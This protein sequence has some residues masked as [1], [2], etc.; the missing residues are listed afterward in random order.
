MKSTFRTILFWMHLVSGLVAG[1]IIGL[2]S[3]TGAALAFEP[4]L[5]QWADREARQ[6]QPPPSGA[7]RLPVEELLARVRAAK[8]GVQPQGVTV[9]ADPESA[10]LVSTGR[11]SGVYVDPYTGDVR[12]QGGKG[13]RAFLHQMEELHRWLATSEDHRALGRG[14]TGVCN[15]AFLF[16]AVSGL[17]LWWPRRWTW[18]T[19]RPVLWFKGGLKGKARDFNWHNAAGFWAMPILVVLTASGVVMSY[20]AVSDLIFTLTGNEPPANSGPFGQTAVKVP[21]PPPGATPLGVDA[22][23]AEAQKQVPAWE[24]ISL[25]MG[26]GPRPGGQREGGPREGAPREGGPRGPQAMTFSIKEQGG[27]PLF[28]S[29]QLSLNPFT[30]EVLRRETFADYNSGRQIRTWLRFL[31]TGQALG[32]AG[33][34]VAGVASL[35][36]AFLMW[37]GFT[38]SWRRFFRRRSTVATTEQELEQ[39]PVVS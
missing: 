37:T 5:E 33:Q 18:K 17:Y 36:G 13:L 8:P 24:S 2:M 29:A 15:A 25:R 1:I 10:V 7:A 12:E 6:V 14:V 27:W 39:P 34:L 3:L 19:V 23:F 4:Q 9:Y 30:A 32:W 22:L 28:A 20:K 35:A 38:L 21:E 26:G 11:G 31:H 16:L